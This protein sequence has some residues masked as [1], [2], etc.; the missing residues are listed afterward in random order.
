M[1][2]QQE[3][4]EFKKNQL[5][6]DRKNS[7]DK[8]QLKVIIEG[9]AGFIVPQGVTAYDVM[10]MSVASGYGHSWIPTPPDK[11]EKAWNAI[12]KRFIKSEYRLK[13]N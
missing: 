6:L 11:T 10:R 3:F 12:C 1:N 9:P 2:I 5:I 7:W 4:E 13:F 8:W